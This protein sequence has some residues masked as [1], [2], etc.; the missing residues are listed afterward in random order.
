MRHEH[1]DNSRRG[2]LRGVLAVVL[3]L[4]RHRAGT[5]RPRSGPR[6]GGP[7][8]VSRPANACA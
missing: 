8:A 3:M 5:A 2:V 1:N 6:R 7:G 4:P